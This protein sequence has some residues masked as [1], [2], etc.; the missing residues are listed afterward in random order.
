M[1]VTLTPTAWPN[2]QF[3]A[4]A[5]CIALKQQYVFHTNINTLAMISTYSGIL[6][7]IEKALQELV[8][9]Y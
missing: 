4:Y 6:S 8:E 1:L 3:L 2:S 7:A 5:G 9:E